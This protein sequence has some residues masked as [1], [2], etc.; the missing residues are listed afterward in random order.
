MS[1]GSRRSRPPRK[2]SSSAEV[3]ASQRWRPTAS[4]VKQVVPTM[5]RK[6]LLAGVRKG[7]R[8]RIP[9]IEM[10]P[11]IDRDGGPWSSRWSGGARFVQTPRL[12]TVNRRLGGQRLDLGHRAE[13]G[14]SLPTRIRPR[15]TFFNAPGRGLVSKGRRAQSINRLITCLSGR[16][17][18]GSE[19]GASGC[20]ARRPEQVCQ[21]GILMTANG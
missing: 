20:M 2:Q 4:R 9:A 13:P 12:A 6:A 19:P 3:S 8:R 11:T 21:K 5:T 1:A 16:N 17:R 18:L 15:P 10:R 14:W 7:R